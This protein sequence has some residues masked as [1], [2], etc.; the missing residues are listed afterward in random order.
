MPPP[1]PVRVPTKSSQKRGQPKPNRIVGNCSICGKSVRATS[2]R[3]YPK[4]WPI[5]LQIY[6]DDEDGNNLAH[7]HCLRRIQTLRTEYLSG[8][9]NERWNKGPPL[10]SPRSKIQVHQ[11]NRTTTT[12]KT[13][14]SKRLP[15]TSAVRPPP[16]SSLGTILSRPSDSLAYKKKVQPTPPPKIIPFQHR[17]VTTQLPVSPIKARRATTPQLQVSN[18]LSKRTS[19]GGKQR[20]TLKVRVVL[21]EDKSDNDDV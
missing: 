13:R 12:T 9:I 2:A 4:S 8:A 21:V 18:E 16:K 14:R 11:T 17:T 3:P 15:F 20:R 10:G 6:F 1:S 7:H 19:V 5:E